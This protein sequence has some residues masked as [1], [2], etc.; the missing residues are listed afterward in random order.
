MKLTIIGTLTAD[1]ALPTFLSTRL[2]FRDADNRQASEPVRAQRHPIGVA[3]KRVL[4]DAALPSLK[5]KSKALAILTD[6]SEEVALSIVRKVTSGTRYALPPYQDQNADSSLHEQD[7]D[8]WWVFRNKIV[9]VKDSR[10]ASRE[11]VITRV[12][13]KVLSEES[14]FAKLKREVDLFEKFEQALPLSREPIPDDVRIFVWRRD[15]G[16]CIRCGSQERIEF[17]HIIPIAKGGSNTERN[18]QLLCEA[19]NRLKG[20]TI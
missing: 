11:E 14:S 12:R 4:A 3:L 1:G 6:M 8:G 5:A 20:T 19:C 15:E 9:E 16:R 7:S 10:A 17:D 13:H 2:V 18:I